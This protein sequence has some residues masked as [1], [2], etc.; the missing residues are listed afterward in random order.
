MPA[1]TITISTSAATELTEA[2]ALQ[3]GYSP[4]L[5]DGSHNPETKAQ[6]S[7]RKI[8]EMLKTKV[9]AYRRHVAMQ[10]A[11]KAGA[12]ADPDIT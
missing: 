3:D 5:E 9:R 7:R 6:F 1:I 4:I 10:S 11:L 8:I 12:G 2:I